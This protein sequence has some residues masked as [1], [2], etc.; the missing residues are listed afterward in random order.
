VDPGALMTTTTTKSTKLT[1]VLLAVVAACGE[2]GDPSTSR[3]PVDPATAPQFILHTSVDAPDRRLNY[4]VPVASLAE[5]TVVDLKKALEVP[6]TSRLFAPPSGGYFSVGSS[7]DMSITRYDLGADGGLTRTGLVSFKDRAIKGWKRT[8]A[9]ISPTKAY[10]LDES[11]VQIIVWN[12]ADLTITGTIDLKMA[13]QPGMATKFVR[14]NFPLRPGRLITSVSWADSSWTNV[15]P[16]TG[17][18]VIDTNIDQVLYFASDKRCRGAAEVVEMPNGDIYFASG[19]DEIVG[20]A[21]VRGLSRPACMLRVKAAEERF[22]PGYMIK[23]SELV[24]GRAACDIIPTGQPNQ[25]L[26]R[27]L[28][29]VKAPWTGADEEIGQAEAWEWWRLDVSSGRAVQATELGMA[30]VYTTY[31][32]SA[33]KV[34]FTRKVQDGAASQFIEVLADGTLRN[35]LTAPGFIWTAVKVY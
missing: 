33:G 35:G 2:D 32:R 19:P 1:V 14:V 25:L 21:E 24:G 9:F 7:E 28:D 16:E 10:Y 3:P 12:P 29:E 20:S 23:L 34:L 13:A 31:S 30:P 15:V 8:M 17:L 26:F 5:G 22:D 11:N 18:L 4:F 27:A 6:G